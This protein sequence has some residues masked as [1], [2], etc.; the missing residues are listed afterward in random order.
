[1]WNVQ[2]S[3]WQQTSLV[4]HGWWRNDFVWI[5]F[6]SQRWNFTQSSRKGYERN[7]CLCNMLSKSWIGWAQ[8][9]FCFLLLNS[10]LLNF[11]IALFVF[12]NS[13]SQFY[14][15]FICFSNSKSPGACLLVPW[16]IPLLLDWDIHLV[17]DIPDIEGDRIFGIQSFSVRLGQ[18][19]VSYKR[20]MIIIFNL[21][22]YSD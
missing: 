19:R 2:S 20:K 4:N 6:K 15:R 18:R 16:N 13:K 3:H 5:T 14:N 12:F 1:M 17:Q 21:C 22:N 10:L 7:T 8:T 11:I 9:A